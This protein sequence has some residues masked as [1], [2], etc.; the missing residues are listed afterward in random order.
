M[1]KELH[2]HGVVVYSVDDK[3]HVKE[4]DITPTEHTDGGGLLIN[5]HSAVRK[6]HSTTHF[7]IRRRRSTIDKI[8]SIIISEKKQP[9][10][11]I[12]VNCDNVECIFEFKVYE[13]RGHHSDK[14]HNPYPQ[15]AI[16][17][18]SLC[19]SHPGLIH[20]SPAHCGDNQDANN[21]TVDIGN[22][23]LESISNELTSVSNEQVSEVVNDNN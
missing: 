16:E 10:S 21:S 5:S 4:V 17:D 8:K 15:Q 9:P 11:G 12:I 14:M 6:R 18:S 2:K 23:E 19:A 1:D 7:P 22:S 3:G 20:L 13:Y